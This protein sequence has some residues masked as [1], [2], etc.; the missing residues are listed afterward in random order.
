ME[1]FDKTD[2]SE[3]ENEYY[4]ETFF[5]FCLVGAGDNAKYNGFINNYPITAQIRIDSDGK[6]EGKYAYESTL[7]KYGDVK[8]SWFPMRGQILL[9]SEYISYI[10]METTN[11]STNETFEYMLL[12]LT[13]GDGTL[14][15]RMFNKRFL[16]GGSTNF[17][18]VTLTPE[19][20]D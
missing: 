10:L 16:E 11:P 2:L 3:S 18:S 14:H 4:R 17:Y 19:V 6:V 15:G 12:D 1:A 20:Q 9:D 13:S 7:K 8:G 5:R